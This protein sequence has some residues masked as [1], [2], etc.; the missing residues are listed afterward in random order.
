LCNRFGFSFFRLFLLARGFLRRLYRLG[1]QALSFSL[2][3]LGLFLSFFGFGAA[4]GFGFRVR[5]CL[6]FA[7]LSS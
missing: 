5:T 1:L 6:G 4:P 3:S 7:L 2:C